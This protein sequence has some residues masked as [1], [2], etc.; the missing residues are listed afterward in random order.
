MTSGFNV[1]V[2]KEH[3]AK[4]RKKGLGH[5]R[6]ET[7]RLVGYDSIWGSTPLVLLP[8]NRLVRRRNVTYDTSDYSWANSQQDDAQPALE[9]PKLV[10]GQPQLANFL[11]RPGLEGL[12]VDAIDRR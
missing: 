6:A 11:Q 9:H 12:D 2:P 7:G 8:K 10:T 1:L 5:L 4:M 3:R